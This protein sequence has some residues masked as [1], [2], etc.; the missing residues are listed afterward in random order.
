MRCMLIGMRGTASPSRT[1][2]VSD[3]DVDRVSPAHTRPT[4]FLDGIKHPVRK[5]HKIRLLSGVRSWESN[6]SFAHLPSEAASG[7]TWT[8]YQAATNAGM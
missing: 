4:N 1:C 5:K 8:T 2:Y 7:E 3:V 6:E